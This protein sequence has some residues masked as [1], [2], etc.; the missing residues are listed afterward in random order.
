[1]QIV[2]IDEAGKGP[3][4]GPLVMCGV[5]ISSRRKYMLKRIGVDDSK[6]LSRKKR[7]ALFEP[8]KK[9]VDDYKIIVILPWEIDSHVMSET[10]NLNK[11]EMGKTSEILSFL[12]PDK[13]F[14]DCPDVNLLSYKDR[15]S[16][17]VSPDMELVVE[18]K[19]EKYE[20]VAAA[21]II[22]K[23]T[24][25]NLIKDLKNE[26]GIDFGSGYSSDR[27]TIAFMKDNWSKKK[28]SKLIRKSW[29]TYK[30]L[31]DKKSQTS[32]GNF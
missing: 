22:A 5:S 12:K 32:L 27:Y 20:V 6:N 25:D 3:V 31:R 17:L 28:Y 26:L 23:V 21:S 14:V 11:L 18:H 16:K 8:V 7:D 13:A 24:R 15:L 29:A 9:L 19:A 4:L 10:S 2:G 30:N 1:M